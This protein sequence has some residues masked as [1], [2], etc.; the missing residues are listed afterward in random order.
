MRALCLQLCAA[1]EERP[2]NLAE[3]DLLCS[4]RELMMLH[5]FCL[6]IPDSKFNID[7]QRLEKTVVLSSRLGKGGEDGAPDVVPYF[8]KFKEAVAR[9]ANQDDLS[10]KQIARFL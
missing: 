2:F 3:F 1:I 4:P 7:V 10:F 8:R 9:P 6:G 5:K